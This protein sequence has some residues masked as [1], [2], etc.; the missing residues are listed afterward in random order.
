MI[1]QSI[2]IIIIKSIMALRDYRADAI[3]LLKF[4][5]LN[6]LIGAPACVIIRVCN[7]MIIIRP[8]N[9]HI[10]WFTCNKMDPSATTILR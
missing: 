2:I 10:F 1:I 9:L 5:F 3:V 4:L 7:S 8:G 6:M